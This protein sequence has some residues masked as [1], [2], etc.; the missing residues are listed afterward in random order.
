MQLGSTGNLS[1]VSCAQLSADHDPLWNDALGNETVNALFETGWRKDVSVL[2]TGS[3]A[4][5]RVNLSLSPI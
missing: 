1:G 4:R 2:L 3:S 5:V